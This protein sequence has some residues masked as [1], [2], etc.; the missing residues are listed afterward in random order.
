MSSLADCLEI[1]EDHWGGRK[2]SA[3]MGHFVRKAISC[4]PGGMDAIAEDLESAAC[5]VSLLASLRGEGLSP[6]SVQTYYQAFRRMLKLAGVDTVRW[7]NAPTPPRKTRE[8]MSND[9]AGRLIGWLDAK[10]QGETGDLARV[11]RGSG[12]RV[13]IEALARDALGIIVGPDCTVLRV[14]G[15]GGHERLIPVVDLGAVGVLADPIRL[16]AIRAIPYLTHLARWRKGVAALGIT[17]RLATPHSLR[18]QY[19]CEALRKSGGNIAMVAEL[20]G[21]SDPA[22]TARYLSVDLS[23]KAEA[24][25]RP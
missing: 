22:V 2:G 18:H 21:H 6:K 10:G 3:S 20:L 1:A 9:D 19:A 24:L 4:V 16:D 7:P 15:K 11:L 25:S 17:S 23:A 5:G 14:T 12:L 8:P 13:R